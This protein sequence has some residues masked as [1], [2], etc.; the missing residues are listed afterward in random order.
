ML[1]LASREEGILI[2]KAVAYLKEYEGIIQ[3][4]AKDLNV[5]VTNVEKMVSNLKRRS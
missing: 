1:K 3:S 2:F 4:I 5:P